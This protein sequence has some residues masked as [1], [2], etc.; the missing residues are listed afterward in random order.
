VLP[1]DWQIGQPTHWQR[2]PNFVRHAA[3]PKPARAPVPA[4][5][6]PAATSG[7]VAKDAGQQPPKDDF[8]GDRPLAPVLVAVPAA[9]PPVP[10]AKP[11]RKP[12]T[13]SLGSRHSEVAAAL[14]EYRKRRWG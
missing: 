11:P 1:A 10:E 13:L 14:L 7:S 4:V 12:T 5:A 6:K 2:D 3:K 8:P 9:A